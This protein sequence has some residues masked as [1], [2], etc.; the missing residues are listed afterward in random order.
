MPGFNGAAVRRPRRGGHRRI[1][2]PRPR[3]LQR[4][5]GPETAESFATTRPRRSGPVASTGPRSGDRGETPTQPTNHNQTNSFNGAAVRRPRRGGSGQ[6]RGRPSAGLQRGRGPETAESGIPRASLRWRS[7][8]FN[9]AAVRRPRRERER[10]PGGRWGM[11]AS[12]GPRS[13]DRGE[14]P[15]I[16]H[17]LRRCEQLQRGRGPETAESFRGHASR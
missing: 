14:P 3:T 10:Q 8:R 11:D 6:R 4:G 13:G 1:H 16:S 2:R 9:G 5:R 17:R 15:A 12:T 7:C